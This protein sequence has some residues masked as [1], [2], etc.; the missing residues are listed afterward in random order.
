M[1]GQFAELA[2]K[3][4]AHD[5][6]LLRSNAQLRTQNQTLQSRNENLARDL[7]KANEASNHIFATD[8]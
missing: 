2:A 3:L 8:S 7:A 4:K 1:T 5:E 6:K